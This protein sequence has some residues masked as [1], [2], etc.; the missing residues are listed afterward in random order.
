MRA[1]DGRRVCP[2][3]C[4]QRQC[5]QDSLLCRAWTVLTLR[6]IHV[7]HHPLS[8]QPTRQPCHLTHQRIVS[9]APS[10]A[11]QQP[12]TCRPDLIDCALSAVI[13]H[14][15]IYAIGRAAQSQLAQCQQIA[16]S[17]EIARGTLRLLQWVHLSGLEPLEQLF[18]WNI[19]HDDFISIIKDMVRHG[20]VHLYPHNTADHVVQTLQMLHIQCGPHINA[21]IQQLLNILPALGVARASHIAVGQLVKQQDT[22]AVRQRRIQI[23]LGQCLALVRH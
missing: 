12:L 20:F 17:K 11:D 16:Q 19:D 1:R 4:C 21:R 14:V 7:D 13:T 22:R 5:L 8:F 15:F 23:K 2:Q 10:N 6:C 18:R 3:P 9:C